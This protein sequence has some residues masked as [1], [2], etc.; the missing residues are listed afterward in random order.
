MQQYLNTI[1]HVFNHGFDKS[2]R[3]GVGTI[4]VFGHQTRYDLTNGFPAVTTKKLLFD[5]V[6]S[7]L[8]WFLRG[9]IDERELC[10][11]LYGDRDESR[12]T[13]WSGNAYAPYWID[14]AKFHGDCGRIYGAQMRSWIKPDGTTVDQL[15]ELIDGIKKDPDSRRHI[16]VNY[17]P[18]EVNEMS[19]NPCHALFQFYV[20]NG[21]LSCQMYQRSADLFLG[22]PYNIAS[23]ALLTHMIAQVCD[24]HVG[25][26]IHTCGDLHI[27]KNHGEQC[28]EQLSR[29]PYSLPT[30]WLNPEI[31]NI[32]DFSMDD[33]KL[34][35][36]QHHPYIKATMAV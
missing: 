9:S 28:I 16:V 20:A 18:G 3:T 25:E 30:L 32:F 8:I 24:L 4:S 26:F 11:I 7:E 35:N 29:T 36:Y 21:R 14:K 34:I 10:E 2:D 12:S 6:K 5:N 17:N 27:Y 15:Q 33:I 1:Q 23:Y 22:V 31:K 13:I 19:L